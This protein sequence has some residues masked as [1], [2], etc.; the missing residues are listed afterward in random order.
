MSH[1]LLSLLMLPLVLNLWNCGEKYDDRPRNTRAEGFVYLDEEGR[2]AID[3]EEWLPLMVNYKVDWR[4]EG[5]EVRISPAH[6]YET[7]NEWDAD[8][9]DNKET[10]YNGTETSII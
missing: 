9:F 10:N 7:P 1:F 4:R 3:G 8:S 2:L 6:Y 5:T